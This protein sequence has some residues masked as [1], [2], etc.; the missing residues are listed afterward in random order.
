[1]I[2]PR[3]TNDDATR[4]AVKEFLVEHLKTKAIEMAFSGEDTKYLKL[5]KEII[6]EAWNKLINE[7]GKKENKQIE[8]QAR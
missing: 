7:Y 2:L 5:A 4:D 6:E 3:F 1:M 8:N